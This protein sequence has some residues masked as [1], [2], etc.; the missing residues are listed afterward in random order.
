MLIS[1]TAQCARSWSHIIDDQSGLKKLASAPTTIIKPKS[2]WFSS[3]E[4]TANSM[5]TSRLC[6]TIPEYVTVTVA[7]NKGGQLSCPTDG[8]LFKTAFN[9]ERCYVNG[10]W[11]NFG[12]HSA[13]CAVFSLKRGCE[14]VNQRMQELEASQPD[15]KFSDIPEGSTGEP[16]ALKRCLS[17]FECYDPLKDQDKAS[18]AKAFKLT[19]EIVMATIKQH[20]SCRHSPSALSQSLTLS[21]SHSLTIICTHSYIDGLS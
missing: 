17:L 15:C 4:K 10:K 18:E 7:R 12:K 11:S 2:S 13:A 8:E 16:T 3:S 9:P 1:R 6:E 21:L 5:R 14:L 19:P 20:V